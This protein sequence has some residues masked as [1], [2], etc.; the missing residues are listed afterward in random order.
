MHKPIPRYRSS[1][2][3]HTLLSALQTPP[4][5]T[6]S[7]FTESGFSTSLYRSAA[8]A[9]YAWFNKYEI[10][11]KVIVPAYTCDRVISALI[12]AHTLTPVF[13]DIDT[14]TGTIPPTALI[15][16]CRQVKPVAIIATHIFGYSPQLASLMPYCRA[17][18]IHVIEGAA[19]S[20]PAVYGTQSQFT[21]NHPDATILSFGKGKLFSLGIGGLL[22]DY[23]A[24]GKHGCKT[25]KV[26][27]RPWQGLTELLSLAAYASPLWLYQVWAISHLKRFLP[28][29]HPKSLFRPDP[30]F[31]NRLSPFTARIISTLV[32]AEAVDRD[33]QHRH[34]INKI[35]LENLKPH[36]LLRTPVIT[37][38][39][40]FITPHYPIFT[41]QKMALHHY[42]VQRGFDTA[43]YF[44]YCIGQLFTQDSFPN[45]ERFAREILLLPNHIGITTAEAHTLAQAINHWI[46]ATD[47]DQL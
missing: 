28:H 10:R 41:P 2:D 24:A 32:T 30:I 47:H 44:N 22:I 37:E 4:I 34:R 18:G 8:D 25:L 6:T 11:G 14:R 20:V 9:L 21:A 38:T 39:E 43:T 31:G 3:L 13:I 45:A 17:E 26:S 27:S 7:P 36:P 40:A 15:D 5:Q 46:P 12:N 42:L 16:A 19:L 1:I 33:L 29:K 35:Y 23:P